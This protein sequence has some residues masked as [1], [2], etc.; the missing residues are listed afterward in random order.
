MR[1]LM[2]PSTVLWLVS[3]YAALAANDLTAGPRGQVV[4]GQLPK[5][6]K[7]VDPTYPPDA[8]AKRIQGIVMLQIT[9]GTNGRVAD[10]KVIQSI[11][12][13]D[14]AAVAAVRQWEF[15]PTGMSGP[16]VA[17][18]LVPFNPSAYQPPGSAPGAN[19]RPT[20]GFE[21]PRPTPGSETN[22][23]AAGP[24]TPRPTP[25]SE[26]PRPAALPDSR[27][28]S[29]AASS[30]SGVRPPPIHSG[31][32]LTPK[33]APPPVVTPSVPRTIVGWRYRP[34][35]G[36]QIV[37]SLSSAF[38]D[39]STA[40]VM[41]AQANIDLK[42]ARTRYWKAFPAGPDFTPAE[43]EFSRK[44]WS[45]DVYHLI[46]ALP[47]GKRN[48][49]KDPDEFTSAL[50]VLKRVTTPLD[51]GIRPLAST[52]FDDLVAAVRYEMGARRPSDIAP[53]F[54]PGKTM[55]ALNASRDR[56]EAYFRA[57]DWA[58]FLASG[59]DIRKF[60]DPKT[61]ALQLIEDRILQ[62]SW[63]AGIKRPPPESEVQRAYTAM[64]DG[65]GEPAVL[66][67]AGK[68]LALQQTN[69]RLVKPFQF[70]SMEA[71][72]TSTVTNPRRAF[73]SL[74]FSEPRGAAIFTMMSLGNYAHRWETGV[75]GYR[76]LVAKYGEERV[77]ASAGR[78]LKAPRT[79]LGNIGERAPR[80]WFGELLKNPAAAL[81]GPLPRF[82]VSDVEGLKAAGGNTVVVTGTVERIIR[83]NRRLLIHF[84][85]VSPSL[86]QAQVVNV[87]FFE[88]DFG[89]NGNRLLGKAVEITAGYWILGKEGIVFGIAEEKQVRIIP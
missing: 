44:L 1:T 80:W 54:I 88:N 70:T 42:N 29:A 75:A 50:D 83:D 37:S 6:T 38:N 10:V 64:V 41:L 56:L 82:R 65:L 72:A 40:N 45:K 20:A 77:I 47:E 49:M 34:S 15:D 66:A 78:V 48:P 53:T 3:A 60:F 74:L 27:P 5:Q 16:A 61:Y 76:D 89:E 58:E 11:P 9:V 59:L 14:A 46:W 52:T 33:P 43:A 13:L 87:D 7:R 19:A 55:A 2:R 79:P 31:S 39:V 71:V 57:R 17:R 85:E 86:V 28:P 4:S 36:R 21:T 73:E 24:G 35:L 25:A 8:L 81:P 69:G 67:A 63:A 22:R 30:G 26:V 62:E 32:E 51:D 84:K 23:P 68:V 12:Q 18:V